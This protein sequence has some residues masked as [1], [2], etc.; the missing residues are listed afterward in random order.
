MQVFSVSHPEALRLFT[1][2]PTA[3]A[4]FAGLAAAGT[5]PVAAQQGVA[6]SPRV[7]ATKFELAVVAGEA[8]GASRPILCS[9]RIIEGSAELALLCQHELGSS[10]EV[11]LVRAGTGARSEMPY[12]S[13]PLANPFE[14]V[15]TLSRT[16]IDVLEAGE[17]ALRIDTGAA[18]VVAEGSIGTPIFDD[19]F[20]IYSM[21]RWSN[22]PCP[23]DGNVCTYDQCSSTGGCSYI[24]HSVS[25]SPAHATGQ[26]NS[27][28]CQI[29]SC[30]GGYSNCNITSS[31]G[32]EVHHNTGPGTC[33]NG[34]NYVDAQAGDMSCNF[35][36]CTF[37]HAGVTFA[38]RSG[39]GEMYYSAT[40]I[41]ASSCLGDIQHGI[42]LKVPEGVDYDLFA[43]RNCVLVD[44]SIL[45]PGEDDYVT[46]QAEEDAFASETFDYQIEVR[47][48]SG[49]SCE[50]WVLE[51]QGRD[52]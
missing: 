42:L 3:L 38:S 44:S 8:P 9:V 45:G 24:N 16:A 19:S 29:T 41:E 52:C 13:A 15:A 27:G 20:D 51:F 17:L 2:L 36:A 39:L 7:F 32:C 50:E 43:Y 48:L 6:D 4:L 10:G 18:G 23:S 28:V 40:N 31:D 35:P 25:C 5:A 46:V 1:R 33:S 34:V 30:D 21:C 11:S 22:F 14:A 26:C 12:W 49:S 37:D 47:W